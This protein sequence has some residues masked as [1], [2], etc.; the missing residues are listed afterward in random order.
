MFIRCTT[1]FSAD[2]FLSALKSSKK[3]C[4]RMLINA[5]LLAGNLKGAAYE[6]YSHT[7]VFFFLDIDDCVNQTCAN[8]ASCLDGVNSY[9]CNCAAGYTG[10]HCQTGNTFF[11]QECNENLRWFFVIS[12]DSDQL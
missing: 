3:F 2:T 6:V 4:N 8:G 5:S 1:H 12:L 7:I 9:S 11:V 10:V